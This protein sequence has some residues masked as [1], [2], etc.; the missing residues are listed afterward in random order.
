[1]IP[2]HHTWLGREIAIKIHA[3]QMTQTTAKHVHHVH[4]TDNLSTS[5]LKTLA[6]VRLSR[7][8]S[9]VVS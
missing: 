4:A 2:A 3:G 9:L 1:M 7:R 6:L 5:V 8:S